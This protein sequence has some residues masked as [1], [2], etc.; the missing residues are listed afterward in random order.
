LRPQRFDDL[1]LLRRLVVGHHDHASI[2]ARI[3]H[4]REPD[5]GVA[6]RALDHG[7]AGL[8]PSATLG[9]QNYPLGRAILDGTT[10]I[11]EFSLAED[12]AARLFAQAAQTNQRGVADRARKPVTYA[13]QSS[14]S[15]GATP[16]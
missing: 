14:S 5:A 12:F 7:A 13:H 15:R 6:G 4:M 3:A 16:T 1:V 2:A 9:V 11:H 8:Q 10:R